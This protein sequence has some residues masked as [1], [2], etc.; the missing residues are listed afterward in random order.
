MPSYSHCNRQGLPCV[1]SSNT[2]HYGE[3]ICLKTKCNIA[4]PSPSDW[5]SL[6]RK[7][8]R[9]KEEEKATLVK[10]IQLYV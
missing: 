9:L 8:K 7:E 2:V 5:Y 6:K 10:L 3:C 1:V 4:S